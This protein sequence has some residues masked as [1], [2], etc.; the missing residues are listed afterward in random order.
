MARSVQ[1]QAKRA[2]DLALKE[3]RER[4]QEKKAARAAA[5]AAG[6]VSPTE[7]VVEQSGPT[8]PDTDAP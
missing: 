4:K 3:R 5:R 7:D 1:S 8:E 2:R 6:D